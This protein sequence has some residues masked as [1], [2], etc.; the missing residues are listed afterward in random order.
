MS[1]D[2]AEVIKS[3]CSAALLSRQEEAALAAKV[4]AGDMAARERM[5]LSNMRL[6]VSIAKTFRNIP[7]ED[8]IDD[9]V[10]G[11]M[12]AVEC[13][14]PARGVR[15]STYA[16]WWIRQ[17]LLRFNQT[18]ALVRLPPDKQTLVGKIERAKSEYVQRL[19]GEP[20]DETL[21]E[22]VSRK[23][24]RYSAENIRSLRTSKSKSLLQ[25]LDG[26][27]TMPDSIYAAAVEAPF[28]PSMRNEQSE[29]LR[30]L[31]D[32]LPLRER[33][34]IM[35]RYFSVPQKT[36]EEVGNVLKI[37]RERVRQIEYLALRKF[38]TSEYRQK[39][40]IE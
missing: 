22:L 5:I 19:G 21:A 31:V 10:F 30:K 35:A 29:T 16:T 34:V 33:Y 26:Q 37:T 39:L 24:R 12:R 4:K 6:V 36:L 13:Y 9:G 27:E 2:L 3:L 17:R 20:S 38:R 28:E 18:Y 8:A 23:G 15:F 40:G 32:S 7:L 11:L 1:G 25:S 14:D